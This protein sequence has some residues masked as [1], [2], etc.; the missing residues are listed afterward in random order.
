MTPAELLLAIEEAGE[1]YARLV[2]AMSVDDFRRPRGDGEWTAAE[3]TGHV[4]EAMST[5]AEWAVT[6]ARRPGMA[7]GRELDDAQR[8]QATSSFLGL[9]AGDAARRVRETIA[10]TTE[11]L[12][13]AAIGGPMG[14]AVGFWFANRQ[15][16][17][18]RSRKDGN[19]RLFPTGSRRNPYPVVG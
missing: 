17:N 5:W 15:Q 8:L 10:A 19:N 2:E 16:I 12:E 6:A 18:G 14:A 11:G 3:V 4:A 13:A 7:V 1:Q 9:A